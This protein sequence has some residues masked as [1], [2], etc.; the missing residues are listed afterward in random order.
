MS[1][2]SD[3]SVQDGDGVLSTDGGKVSWIKA[4]RTA[5]RYIEKTLDVPVDFVHSFVVCFLDGGV[6]DEENRGFIRLWEVRNDWEN[7]VW[8]YAR[9]NGEGWT[10]FLEQLSKNDKVIQFAGLERLVFGSR[11]TVKVS[12]DGGDY[13]LVVQDSSGLTREDSGGL[14]GAHQGYNFIWLASTIKS[15]RNNGNWSTG[16]IES[17]SLTCE[18]I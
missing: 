7:R 13:R 16:Y 4:D 14:S 15:R 18:K 11:F 17:L 6:E 2:F 12:R 9:K 1:G 3:W 5:V 8:I 10:I